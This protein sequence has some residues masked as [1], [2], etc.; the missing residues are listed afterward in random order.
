MK[1]YELTLILDP[2][3]TV[4]KK[5]ALIEKIKK[6]LE[7]SGGKVEKTDEWG[8]KKLAYLIRKFEEGDFL[9]LEIAL[10]Q[11]SPAEI[12]KKLSLE[13]AILRCLLVKKE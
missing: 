13:E 10:P 12:E 1:N 6:I 9:F 5:K 8:K 2:N 3:L 11:Q 7:A 4:E